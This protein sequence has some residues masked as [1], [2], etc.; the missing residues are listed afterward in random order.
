MRGTSSVLKNTCDGV[1]V[2]SLSLLAF[3]IWPL[4]RS[5]QQ[6]RS[7]PYT[8]CALTCYA[9][10][11]PFPPSCPCFLVSPLLPCLLP[12]ITFAPSLRRSLLLS[13]G[14]AQ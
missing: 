6:S 7:S 8:T 9:L 3:G 11:H 2:G 13:W 1:C 4:A 14:R 10:S 12:C 5:P